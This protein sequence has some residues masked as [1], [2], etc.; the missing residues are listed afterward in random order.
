VWTEIVSIAARHIL[1]TQLASIIFI[2]AGMQFV[3]I[4]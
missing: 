4:K 1:G 3:C 2:M